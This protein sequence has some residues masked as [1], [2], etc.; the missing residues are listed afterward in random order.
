MFNISLQ[1]TYIKHEPGILSTCAVGTFK[2][3]IIFLLIK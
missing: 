3:K 1:L 2:T